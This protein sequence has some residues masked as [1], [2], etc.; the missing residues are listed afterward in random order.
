M[1]IH[2]YTHIYTRI[3]IYIYICRER[4]RCTHAQLQAADSHVQA[5]QDVYMNK[6]K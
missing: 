5:Q 4:E 2:I 6:A 3:Y 1:Y